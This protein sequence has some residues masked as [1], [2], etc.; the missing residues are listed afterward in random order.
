MYSTADLFYIEDADMSRGSIAS[1]YAG[2]NALS[3]GL[4]A[5]NS[6]VFLL[7]FAA[8][9]RGL[10]RIATELSGDR[11]KWSDSGA[12]LQLAPPLSPDGYHLFLSHVWAH[13]QDLAGSLKS[14]FCGLV[15]GIRVFL[16]V[17]DLKDITRLEEHVQES[18]LCETIRPLPCPRQTAVASL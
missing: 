11:L 18:E 8:S 12:A 6:V 16:D 9:Y 4:I 2:D 10:R 15:P 1:E 5:A 7:I 17:D 3:L 13:G 14:T